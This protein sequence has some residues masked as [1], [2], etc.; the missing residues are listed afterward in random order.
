MLVLKPGT[1]T[2]DMLGRIEARLLLIL[3]DTARW[4]ELEGVRV[5]TITSL[6]RPKENDSGVHALG[7]GVDLSV[8]GIPSSLL[9]PLQEYLNTKYQYD[10]MRPNM[11]TCVLHIGNGYGT[12]KAEHIHLQVDKE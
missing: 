12:D 4:L 11:Q 8:H 7:R 3:A 5:L 6:I 10:P 2:W 9:L 1:A